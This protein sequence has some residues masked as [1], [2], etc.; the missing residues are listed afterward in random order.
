V[1]SA[2]LIQSLSALKV[3]ENSGNAAFIKTFC[4]AYN[5]H[6]VLC[7]SMAWRYCIHL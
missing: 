3:E 5:S 1:T 4:K 7:R 6:R 2:F